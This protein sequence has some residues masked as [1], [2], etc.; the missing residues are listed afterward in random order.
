MIRSTQSLEIKRTS[1]TRLKQGSKPFNCFVKFL[2]I[3]R[4]SITR[5][6]HTHAVDWT[7]FAGVFLKSKEPRLRDWNY[8][9]ASDVAS[10]TVL[11]IKRTSITR[12][13]LTLWKWSIRHGTTL[14]SKEPRLRDWNEILI[15]V[16]RL[17][18]TTWNQKNLDYEIETCPHNPQTFNAIDLKSKE[19]RLRDWN[20]VCQVESIIVL[21]LKSKE[22]RLRDWNSRTVITHTLKKLL[23]KSKEPRLRDWNVVCQVESIIVLHLKSKEPRLRDWNCKA[24]IC[25]F[26]LL[27]LKSKEPRLRDWNPSR[28]AVGV[29]RRSHRL[30]IKRTSITRLKPIREADDGS[31]DIPWNQKNLDYEIETD[32]PEPLHKITHPSWNQKNLDYEI[33]TVNVQVLSWFFATRLKSKEPRLRDW[34]SG[35]PPMSA[36]VSK[37]L[38]IKRTSITRLKHLLSIKRSPCSCI[39]KSK[40]PRLRD[41]NS[42]VIR[43]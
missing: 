18:I 9:V 33:E 34:N 13:K 3:K 30:E 15:L 26:P 10:H 29:M 24:V 37:G 23:L 14:K 19:P 6:K 35:L 7:R 32:I 5:L 21:H 1:I 16:P 36:F 25:L 41:W 43:L 20:V 42:L 38:E 17:N 12:L 2:E 27:C 11:E 31:S 28:C 22:P 39:L 40:E 8:T 4:T